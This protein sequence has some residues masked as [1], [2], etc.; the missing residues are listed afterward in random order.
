MFKKFGPY[1]A[2]LIIVLVTVAATP[3]AIKGYVEG[4]YQVKVAQVELGWPVVFKGVTVQREGLHAEL[5]EVRATPWGSDPVEV[6]GGTAH[7]IQK[8]HGRSQE[9]PGRR[10]IIAR[11]L[12]V[13]VEGEGFQAHLEGVNLDSSYRFQSGTFTA[14]GRVVHLGPGEVS[15]DL[16]S[17]SLDSAEVELALPFALPKVPPKG[18]L[19]VENV[20]ADRGKKS[21]EIG[22]LSYGPLMAE[23][24]RVEKGH[25]FSGVAQSVTVNHPWVDVGPV[26]VRDMGFGL[27]PIGASL[28]LDNTVILVDLANYRIA[29]TGTCGE[30]VR[31]LPDERPEALRVP[32][33]NWNGDINFDVSAKG[34]GDIVFNFDCKYKC[35]EE[36]IKSLRAG[37]VKYMAYSSKGIRFERKVGRGS[38]DWADITK[39]PPL[40]TKAFITLEDPGFLGHRGIIVQAL[41]NSLT[42]NLKLG[43]FFRGGSTI[44]Q[45]LA[46][47]LWLRRHKTLSRK[48]YE[49]LLA[50]ALESC[51]TKQEI[52][53]L[54]LNVVEFGP[55]LYGIAPAAK[56]YFDKDVDDLLPVEAFFLARLLPHPSHVI[57]PANGGLENAKA[58]MERL[59]AGGHIED[60][61]LPA[62]ETSSEG[63]QT[64]E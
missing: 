63:W 45:Q 3:R 21:A 29:G 55:D 48:V 27:D 51:L 30:W 20:K 18:V 60:V 15:K 37:I 10:S 50:M 7:I 2:L 56:H 13:T 36:P 44:T 14:D 40:V 34:R 57:M 58:L 24:V 54:Y 26:T 62:E 59:V 16:Q 9:T 1:L 6:R 33:E 47:N 23:H 17:V 61:Y 25:G 39:V 31:A 42:D 12:R 49:A 4:H 19:R 43:E 41:R 11:G 35:S 53:E 46:K 22:K 28:L 8:G 5:Q 64:N 38:P 32:P 52:L